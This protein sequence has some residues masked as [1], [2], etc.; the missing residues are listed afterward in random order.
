MLFHRRVIDSDMDDKLQQTS[1]LVPR[2]Y[3]L[4]KRAELK[5]S[6]VN[7]L[8]F[9]AVSFDRIRP[10][11][12]RKKSYFYEITFLQLRFWML[13]LIQAGRL[14]TWVAIIETQHCWQNC[15]AVPLP[16]TGGADR[17]EGVRGSPGSDEVLAGISCFSAVP[18]ALMTALVL[19]LMGP[20]PG[21]GL[22]KLTSD[23]RLN[24]D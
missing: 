4:N 16:N 13:V 14:L 5:C 18:L 7:L 23:S 3:V 1:R 9:S 15:W 2:K 24:P 22:V 17:A 11:N 12:D 19:S 6:G 10:E 8:F 20:G 21:S